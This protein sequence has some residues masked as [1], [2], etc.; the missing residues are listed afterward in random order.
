MD[1]LI[2]RGEILRTGGISSRNTIDGP[3]MDTEQ[4][5]DSIREHILLPMIDC[6]G[7]VNVFVDVGSLGWLIRLAH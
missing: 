6:Y 1:L 2:I 5:F 4:C 7:Q 3:R